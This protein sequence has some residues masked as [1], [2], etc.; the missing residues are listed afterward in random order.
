M[1]VAVRVVLVVGLA[2]LLVGMGAHYD[3]TRERHWPY[4]TESQL[5]ADFDGHVGRDVFLIEGV[6]RTTGPDTGV[7]EVGDDRV[8][9][10]TVT[11]IGPGVEAGTIVQIYG[12]VRPGREIAARKVVVVQ[13]AGSDGNDKFLVSGVGAVVILAAFFR[14]WRVNRGDLALE[15]RDG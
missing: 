3:V 11:G 10:A 9:N 14:Y 1:H 7:V 4:P 6:E 5:G 12:T 13:P 8:V 2:G 15:G